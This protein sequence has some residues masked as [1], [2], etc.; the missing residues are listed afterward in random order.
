MKTVG[1]S[2]KLNSSAAQLE[3]TS[4]VYAPGSLHGLKGKPSSVSLQKIRTNAPLAA[5][6]HSEQAAQ[7]KV[8]D[9]LSYKSQQKIIIRKLVERNA[10]FNSK[11]AGSVPRQQ[12]LG[13]VNQIYGGG[14]S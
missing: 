10:S 14:E 3:K 11:A 7:R 13:Y 9:L 6:L 1:K 12:N 8:T 2:V 5:A 4:E